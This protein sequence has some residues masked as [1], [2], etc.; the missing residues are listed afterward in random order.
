MSRN[1]DPDTISLV[2]LIVLLFL[3]VIVLLCYIVYEI[4]SPPLLTG[5]PSSSSSF[6]LLFL[7]VILIYSLVR[8]VFFLFL[9]LVVLFVSVTSHGCDGFGSNLGVQGFGKR[10]CGVA[11]RANTR[12]VFILASLSNQIH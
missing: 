6:L 4:R 8:V 10:E 5:P 3:L 1:C 12:N 9:H 7:L 11:N 2:I